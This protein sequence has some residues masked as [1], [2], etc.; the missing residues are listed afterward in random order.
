MLIVNNNEIRIER[1]EL[2]PWGTNAYIIVCTQTNTSALIDAPGDVSKILKSLEDTTPEYIL[3]THSH[4]DHTGALPELRSKLKIPSAIHK[5]DAN[6]LPYMPE[7]LLNGGDQLSLGK[8]R[9]E[10]L[11]TPGH[12]AGSLCFRVGKYLISGDTI[13]P[14]GPG[15]T[16]SPDD[17][18]QIVKAITDKI[19]VL[20]DETEVYPGHGNSTVLKKEKDEFAIFSSR[21]H[22][23]HLCGDVLW[24][25]S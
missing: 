3:I 9:V 15:R 24:L 7:M 12:T 2:G 23:Q 4:S 14:G 19:F 21:P 5:E 10:V 8:I 18:T 6:L 17:F 1:L 25:S 20:P 11:H 22:H 16:D 13:F